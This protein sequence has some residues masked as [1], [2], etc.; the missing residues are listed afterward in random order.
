MPALPSTSIVPELGAVKRTV[1]LLIK[2]DASMTSDNVSEP[3]D[4]GA[5]ERQQPTAVDQQLVD[6]LMGRVQSE[7]VQLTGE[8]GLLRQL[9][10]RLRAARA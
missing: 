6:E 4:A 3:E 10:K 7:G 9:T 8:G 5:A 1:S 2:G